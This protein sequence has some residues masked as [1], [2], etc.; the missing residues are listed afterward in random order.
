[1]IYKAKFNWNYFGIQ[2]VGVVVLL[3]GLTLCIAGIIFCRRMAKKKAE[4]GSSIY[5][6]IDVK[7]KKAMKDNI[8][9]RQSDSTYK[10]LSSKS[11]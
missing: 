1:M 2:W 3:V 4:R 6:D 5:Y 8:E 10:T 11:S 7:K 9:E